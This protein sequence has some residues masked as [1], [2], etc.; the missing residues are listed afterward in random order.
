[1]LKR[2]QLEP[3]T[4][5]DKHCLTSAVSRVGDQNWTA[6]SRA[7][8]NIY[9]DSSKWISGGEKRSVEW[10]SNKQCAA[11]YE[12]LLKNVPPRRKKRSDRTSEQGN[13]TESPA[14]I[15][16]QNCRQEFVEEL[17]KTIA[18]EQTQYLKLLKE[19]EDILAGRLDHRLEEMQEE[20]EAKERE[21][22]IKIKLKFKLGEKSLSETSSGGEIDRPPPPPPP[23]ADPPTTPVKDKEAGHEPH[24]T[25]VTTS[26]LLTSLLQ[27][28]SPLT[29]PSSVTPT[30]SL[31]LNSS[32]SVPSNE[33]PTLSK[34]L[35][36]S[37]P[38]PTTSTSQQLSNVGSTSIKT[39]TP[40]TTPQPPRPQAIPSTPLSALVE[41][42]STLA[43]LRA[44]STPAHTT[45]AIQSME[46]SRS[47]LVTVSLPPKPE[48]PES[49]ED[50]K[51]VTEPTIEEVVQSVIVSE[52][53]NEEAL[54]HSLHPEVEDKKKGLPRR[55]DLENMGVE[56]D[57]NTEF[58][59]METV[60][61][62]IEKVQTAIIETV[63]DGSGGENSIQD[64]RDLSTVAGSET[65]TV[66]DQS[67]DMDLTSDAVDLIVMGPDRPPCIEVN[68]DSDSVKD[69][70]SKGDNI[71][72]VLD[73]DEIQPSISAS[74][75]AELEEPLKDGMTGGKDI[76]GEKLSPQAASIQQAE[77]DLAAIAR[78][79]EEEEAAQ[80]ESIEIDEKLIDKEAVVVVRRVEEDEL[81]GRRLEAEDAKDEKEEN[82]D[83]EEEEEE[84]ATEE[85]EEINDR[86]EVEVLERDDDSELEKE[87]KV[88]D[89]KEDDVAETKIPDE[90]DED[91]RIDDLSSKEV[92]SGDEDDST[93]DRD[94]AVSAPVVKPL[95]EVEEVSTGT[96]N[97]SDSGGEKIDDEVELEDQEALEMKEAV[98]KQ[99]EKEETSIS[100][101]VEVREEPEDKLK[102]KMVEKSSVKEDKHEATL[103]DKVEEVRSGKRE[104]RRGR[105]TPPVTSSPVATPVSDRTLREKRPL[106]PSSSSDGKEEPTPR[107]G[108]RKRTTNLSESSVPCS[109]SPSTVSNDDDKDYR[110]WKKSILLV[111]DRIA[112]HKYASVFLKPINEND[113]PG[114]FQIIKCPTDLTT[115]KRQ[116]ESGII[117]NTV[118]FQREMILMISN[119]IIYNKSDTLVHKMANE[120][121]PDMKEAMETMVQAL[122]S[123]VLLDQADSRPPV[124]A[125]VSR[126]SVSAKGQGGDDSGTPSG[127]GQVS[128]KRKRQ[129]PSDDA[130]SKR[131]RSDAS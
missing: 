70:E 129:Q 127:A 47:Q 116:I 3:W 83:E 6:V 95:V 43:L 94:S 97:T 50:M 40:V 96:E 12:H 28:P 123:G 120:M 7:T 16:Q 108:K 109:P 56:E 78:E 58:E 54:V 60:E 99:V 49:I 31:I 106:T 1:M 51:R 14:E 84:E 21:K 131:K 126:A 29:R 2:I 111:Y 67:L 87:E 17:K 114:Y 64:I 36:S 90:T 119:A 98:V 19:Y 48:D 65:T 53:P 100:S 33:S 55:L 22:E 103:E 71:E 35:E 15:L 80:E 86:K 82:Q 23:P 105:N 66:D 113:A 38:T 59:V 24:K 34:L 117:R 62:M 124:T 76:L 122:G 30:I 79:E 57:D 115:I 37:C 75:V 81:I 32:P 18:E 74:D 107:A 89:L 77:A 52:T 13:A 39:L 93:Q 101:V 8:R 102:P 73:I 110:A 121:L 88:E 9:E 130:R 125:R 91:V 112:A 104:L 72:E 63:G 45:P 20:Y 42:S 46:H 4:A 118:D 68:R 61:E 27:S 128:G 41:P 26:P 5:F 25:S 11:Q 10:F 44:S 92:G 85:V 69:D